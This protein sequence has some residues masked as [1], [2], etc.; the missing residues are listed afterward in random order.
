MWEGFPHLKDLEYY[1]KPECPVCIMAPPLPESRYKSMLGIE[2][3]L[4]HQIPFVY[5]SMES[6][7]LDEAMAKAVAYS[8]AQMLSLPEKVY[9][10][11]KEL[12]VKPNQQVRLH[13][14]KTDLWDDVINDELPS[15]RA[16]L[17]VTARRA[18]DY[19]PSR[20]RA[21]PQTDWFNAF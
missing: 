17:L 4:K 2:T 18:T 20:E 21:N 11:A 6:T 19:K 1:E 9:K 7:G 5:V 10:L 16:S 8:P 15:V 14:P 3:M 13:I 12:A